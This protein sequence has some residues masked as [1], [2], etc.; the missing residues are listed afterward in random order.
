MLETWP[1]AAVWLIGWLTSLVAPPKMLWQVAK[2]TSLSA[3]LC[4]LMLVLFS[5]FSAAPA[6]RVGL[7][8]IVLVAILGWVVTRFA[9]HYL[10]GEPNQIMFIQ[11]TLFTLANVGLIV[12]S[13]HLLLMLLGWS[14]TSVGLHKLL[15]FYHQRRAAQIVSHKKFII[16]RL[17]DV[18]LLMA[19]ALTYI[20]VGS[21]N[22]ADINA[23]AAGQS[24]LSVW[25]ELTMVLVALAAILKTAQLPLH[26]W[27]IQVMEA[28][29]PISAL[30]HAGVVNLSGF[31]LLRMAPL[32]ALSDIA[33]TLLVVVGSLSAALAAMVM[34]TRISI[35]VRL[36]WST[37]AQMGFMLME[38]GL[39]LYELALLHLVAHSLYKAYAFL[40]AG[41]AVEQA[42]LQRL[43]EPTY[44]VTR[45]HLYVLSPLVSAAVI[46]LSLVVW[47]WVLPEFHV[48]WVALIILT[49]GFAPLLWPQRDMSGALFRLGLVRVLLLTQLYFIWHLLFAAAVPNHGDPHIALVIWVA[50][51]FVAL[52]GLQLLVQLY[53]QHKW[54]R[55]LYP[56]AYNGFYLDERFTLITFKI[57][58]LPPAQT[59]ASKEIIS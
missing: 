5:T 11:F 59:D 58:P 55:R 49:I 46:G 34:L 42:R 16:S 28:P 57:W 7:V 4:A 29:T 8:V 33:Q 2:L 13:D 23:H 18:L 6:D 47:Q 27:L 19:V 50:L 30:L 35:K 17:A 52:F 20:D 53:P 39:G 45:K 26:G 51:V 48:S 24:E 3:L 43:L 38:I 1:F 14:L 22:L 37:C 36:A 15:L 31:V 54:S 44:S 10:Q 32:L 40:S 12:V 56:W 25:L 41:E 9:K 21:L